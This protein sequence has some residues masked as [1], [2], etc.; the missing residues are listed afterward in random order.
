MIKFLFHL[1]WR[2]YIDNSHCSEIFDQ[3]TMTIDVLQQLLSGEYGPSKRVIC[4]F[5]TIIHPVAKTFIKGI[6]QAIEKTQED[7]SRR[8]QYLLWYNLINS[9]CFKGSY[10]RPPKLRQDITDDKFGAEL[11]RMIRIDVLVHRIT[12][13]QRTQPLEKE[14][15]W[16]LCSAM[17][18]ANNERKYQIFNKMCCILL[19]FQS[20][21][22]SETLFK[23]QAEIHL[24]L[25]GQKGPLE[26][27]IGM[28]HMLQPEQS[29]DIISLIDI[30][31]DFVLEL[32]PSRPKNTIHKL[33]RL[34]ATDKRIGSHG[35]LIECIGRNTRIRWREELIPYLVPM[36]KAI[37]EQN[38]AF[39]EVVFDEFWQ[40][41]DLLKMTKFLIGEHGL[42]IQ[43]FNKVIGEHPDRI[44]TE[45]FD[46][47]LEVIVDKYVDQTIKLKIAEHPPLTYKRCLAEGNAETERLLDLMEMTLLPAPYNAKSHKPL[48]SNYMNVVCNVIM[49]SFLAV[50]TIYYNC[51][52]AEIDS[53]QMINYFYCGYGLYSVEYCYRLLTH[54]KG[55][56]ITYCKKLI[57]NFIGW[58][59]NVKHQIAEALMGKS[60]IDHLFGHSDIYGVINKVYC[61]VGGPTDQK[62]DEKV[63]QNIKK[64]RSSGKIQCDVE[65]FFTHFAPSDQ[66]MWDTSI[67]E[68]D[69]KKRLIQ[70]MNI[71]NVMM[72]DW[73][74]YPPYGNFLDE[75]NNDSRSGIFKNIWND[76]IGEATDRWEDPKGLCYK[77]FDVVDICLWHE[78][79]DWR[80]DQWPFVYQLQDLCIKYNIAGPILNHAIQSG[81]NG[82]TAFA[83]KLGAV[84]QKLQ[85][86]LKLLFLDLKKQVTFKW[87]RKYSMSIL[88]VIYNVR[89]KPQWD[90]FR[91]QLRDGK[92]TMYEIQRHFQVVPWHIDEQMISEE[93]GKTV[94][95][96]LVTLPRARSIFRQKSQ[97]EDLV[98]DR[99]SRAK[100][101]V[102][103]CLQCIECLST[104][105][106]TIDGVC[107]FQNILSGSKTFNG[108]RMDPQY[109]SLK[110]TLDSVQ[111]FDFHRRYTS[112]SGE[113]GTSELG[114]IEMLCLNPGSTM[115]MA[116]LLDF[117]NNQQNLIG[118]IKC[119]DEGLKWLFTLCS[120]DIFVKELFMLFEDD[121]QC[122]A[123]S[124]SCCFHTCALV[125]YR[126]AL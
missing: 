115:T 40:N 55:V 77:D 86:V 45:C 57:D 36:L 64:Y 4:I 62:L 76:N 15:F 120:H 7:C 92:S 5:R 60:I 2:L 24:I 1:Y 6:V 48:M 42:P 101:A 3:N 121:V 32:D 81:I 65:Y 23:C 103:S 43:T 112:H 80:P 37:T 79:M 18:A 84:D 105:R 96:T 26:A 74:W 111:D 38:R 31:S 56:N 27:S 73:S 63:E 108:L 29:K 9:I 21:G 30:V 102:V 13:V 71:H 122:M 59:Q 93:I 61:D 72:M 106:I 53:L 68:F 75:L 95:S 58:W 89:I 17:S 51:H 66:S 39:R 14:G 82:V 12:T 83:S 100:N 87:N 35:Q 85:E 90:L 91:H 117:W 22:Y 52:D 125:L 50:E 97:D 11:I 99:I 33:V 123:Y 78:S 94:L 28:Y 49:E 126:P 41:Y 67:E 124:L 10:G 110:K 98:R 25:S 70:G 109:Q 114:A 104:L 88:R 107:M 69:N 20:S 118:K 47:W 8:F 34:M 16:I 54:E 119:E 113:P 46:D 44:N 116:Y 19:V